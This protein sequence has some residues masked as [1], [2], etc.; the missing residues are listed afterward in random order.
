[1]KDQLENVPVLLQ[2]VNKSRQLYE[3][4]FGDTK[5]FIDYYYEKMAPDNRILAILEED[6][7]ISMLHLVP[8]ELQ[9]SGKTLYI[10]AVATTKPK[11]RQ[12]YMQKLMQTALQTA[13]DEKIPFVY[14]VPANPAVYKKYDFFAMGEKGIKPDCAQFDTLHLKELARY[15]ALSSELI[16][17]L[18]NIFAQAVGNSFDDYL[19]HD[20]AYY[21]TMLKVLFLE[22]GYVKLYGE[23]D[24]CTAYEMV[25]G[26]ETAEWISAGMETRSYALGRIIDITA[27]VF[28]EKRLPDGLYKIVDNW[29]LDN[30]GLFEIKAG[31]AV[32]ATVSEKAGEAQVLPFRTYTVAELGDFLKNRR[33]YLADEI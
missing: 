33:I 31:R 27:C 16:Q 17:I 3:E 4:A 11:K 14:L 9:N 10:F 8:K 5:T 6:K 1:M 29:I 18:K 26:D 19:L 25:S 30:N 21:E 15:D 7:V 32:K 28:D 13:A 20:D 23:N 22:N 24:V 12:G 2:D